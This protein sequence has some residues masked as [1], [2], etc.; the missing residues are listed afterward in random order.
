[1]VPNQPPVNI[2]A[3]WRN[4]RVSVKAVEVLTGYNFFTNVPKNTQELIKRRIDRE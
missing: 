2:N 1:I 4:F 3:P